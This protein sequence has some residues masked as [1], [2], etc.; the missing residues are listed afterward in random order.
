MAGG[1]GLPDAVGEGQQADLGPPGVGKSAIWNILY[2]PV[3]Y[4]T[5]HI[6]FDTNIIYFCMKKE[7]TNVL[8]NTQCM[9]VYKFFCMLLHKY[10][11]MLQI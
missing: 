11:F 5:K 10:L 1:Q 9:Y 3:K 2:I 8:V 7:C 6:K 4:Y